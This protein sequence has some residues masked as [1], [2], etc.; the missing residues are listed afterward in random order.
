MSNVLERVD[1]QDVETAWKDYL[2]VVD[3]QE[4]CA[5]D[6]GL[7]Y[8]HEKVDQAWNRYQALDQAY[9]HPPKRILAISTNEM[10]TIATGGDTKICIDM[11]TGA[12][13]H[14]KVN[15]LTSVD[16]PCCDRPDIHWQEIGS[17]YLDCGEVTDDLHDICECRTCGTVLYDESVQPEREIK[18]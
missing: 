7:A 3:D 11:Q 14:F 5:V 10:T 6:C 16:Q 18:F 1:R 4:R 17:R 8:D 15:Q 9:K 13:Y 12:V 2:R